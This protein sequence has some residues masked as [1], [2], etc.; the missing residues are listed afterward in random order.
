VQRPVRGARARTR[1]P[2]RGAPSSASVATSSACAIPLGH[3]SAQYGRNSS[4]ANAASSSS[5]LGPRGARGR[6]RPR[7]P[8]SV[9]GLRPAVSPVATP[10]LAPTCPALRLSGHP[11]PPPTAD[12]N[13]ETRT[14]VSR[15]VPASC[16][17]VHRPER[18]RHARAFP[19]GA[20][21]S[22]S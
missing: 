17:F 8:R 16:R 3:R 7:R 2:G 4:S 21:G 10:C 5:E 9:P 22:R 19:A 13:E 1:A 14:D 20:L 11:S 18:S 15:F 6:A 12:A